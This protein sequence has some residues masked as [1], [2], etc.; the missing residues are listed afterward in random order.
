M[1]TTKLKKS[2]LLYEPS[3]VYFNDIA[4]VLKDSF[5]ILKA[6]NGIHAIE[7][8]KNNAFDIKVIL[9]NSSM[10]KSELL[11]LINHCEIISD[12]FISS[13][14]ITTTDKEILSIQKFLKHKSIYNFFNLSLIK[15]GLSTYIS[16]KFIKNKFDHLKGISL[17]KFKLNQLVFDR[18]MLIFE[19]R[20]KL[21][22]V[23]GL[24]DPFIEDVGEIVL[25]KKKITQGRTLQDIITLFED[26]IGEKSANYET[27]RVVILDLNHKQTNELKKTLCPSCDC[28]MMTTH[29]EV[30]KYIQTFTFDLLL[31]STTNAS[32]QLQETQNEDTSLFEIINMKDPHISVLV[33]DPDTNDQL[34]YA[35]S[36]YD[37]HFISSKNTSILDI[38]SEIEDISYASYCLEVLPQ[39][40]DI[41]K[42]QRVSFRSRFEQLNILMK[43]TDEDFLSMT[44][45]YGFFG[46]FKC[47]E[48]PE[49]RVFQKITDD[50]LKEFV[51]NLI[52]QH[53]KENKVSDGSKNDAIKLFRENKKLSTVL[54][55][56][57]NV[58][59]SRLLKEMF[60]NSY[61][62]L[63]S[64]NSSDGLTLFKMHPE[65]SC[66]ILDYSLNNSDDGYNLAKSIRL[67]NDT[68]PI[69]FHSAH[70]EYSKPGL[71]EK[72][73][74]IKFAFKINKKESLDQ[75]IDG[76]HQLVNKP[77][78]LKLVTKTL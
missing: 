12:S 45:V 22:K 49:N 64:D 48:Y 53:K 26:D 3:E 16:S 36:Q 62:I 32:K 17:L 41:L 19:E 56:E 65:I 31:I 69:I 72:I 47:E 8:Y 51:F 39:M 50:K 63:M 6:D 20:K 11:N 15:T 5:E 25:S 2:I 54:I 4:S 46:E 43:S 70:N 1:F 27:P 38:T 61:N 37:Y 57:D 13:L 44:I 33:I 77:T 18:N 10:N 67:L 28:H 78:S 74:T 29:Q 30:K 59:Y 76:V 73:N 7:L 34:S 52:D 23:L 66:V 42:K 9:L 71:I 24:Q 68:V 35:E 58:L 60:K 40:L 75:L 55:V 14:V 21:N